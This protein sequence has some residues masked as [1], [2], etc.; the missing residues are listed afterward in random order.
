MRRLAGTSNSSEELA[1]TVHL[2]V[3]K[4][5]RIAEDGQRAAHGARLGCAACRAP[6]VRVETQ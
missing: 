1:D 3:L 2:I 6:L 4:R 5:E